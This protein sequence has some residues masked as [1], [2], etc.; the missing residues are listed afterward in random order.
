MEALQ[1]VDLNQSKAEAM[2]L[3]GAMSLRGMPKASEAEIAAKAEEFEAVFLSQ[4][5]THM[6]DGIETNETFGGGHGED[7]Y[8]SMMVEEYGE[9]IARSGG[10][11]VADHVKA[12]MIRLQG[13]Q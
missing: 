2:Q 5:L 7:V 13:M 9:I 6:F 11:G 4:M 12:E 1:T 3:R 8:K 10:I